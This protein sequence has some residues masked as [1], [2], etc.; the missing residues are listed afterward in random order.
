[1]SSSEAAKISQ[2]SLTGS[3]RLW[4]LLSRFPRFL[5]SL[6]LSKNRQATQARQAEDWI[7]VSWFKI[8]EPTV[9][10]KSEMVLTSDSVILE[11][12]SP[13]SNHNMPCQCRYLHHIVTHA[14]TKF[15]SWILLSL[16]SISKSV[17]QQLNNKHS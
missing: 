5:S 16:I 7:P 17:S 8:K 3:S 1:M 15:N 9:I 13:S 12:Y 6:N 2:L 10:M 11:H 14:M 4:G